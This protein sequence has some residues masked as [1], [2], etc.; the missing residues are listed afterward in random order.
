MGA[1][2]TATLVSRLAA[3][4]ASWLPEPQRMTVSGGVAAFPEHA[5]GQDELVALATAALERAQQAGGGR[6]SIYSGQ[7]GEPERT[8]TG[9]GRGRGAAGRPL[10]SARAASTYAGLLAGELGLDAERAERLRV[11]AF[12]YDTGA[13]DG[14]A[15]RERLSARVA[16]GA[17]DDE[18]AGWIVARERPPAQRPLETRILVVAEAFVLA[19]GHAAGAA[20]GRA[21][22]E[23][24]SRAD[25]EQ[26][27]RECVQA[28]ERL[29][30]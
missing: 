27:D 21:L 8:R 5:G 26:L 23:L 6:I 1:E 9:R 30:A 22:A 13:D 19:D 25:D 11:A 2:P 29:L 4:F 3:T 14:P 17:L 28:L 12:L 20:A 7:G 18:A 15:E 10:R 16:A 24:W